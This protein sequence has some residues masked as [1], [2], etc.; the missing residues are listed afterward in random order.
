MTD[1]RGI[2]ENMAPV[3]ER[4]YVQIPNAADVRSYLSGANWLREQWD[5]IEAEGVRLLQA[6]TPELTYALFDLYAKT[7][8]R[9]EYERAYFERRRR[10]NT[11]ALLSLRSP[12][13]YVAPLLDILWAICDEYTW[14]IPAHLPDRL[15]DNEIDL[16]AAETGFALSE[17][18]VLLRQQLPQ[19]VQDRI[20]R[21][22]EGRVLTPFLEH[23]PYA[24]ETAIHNWS[25]VCAGSVGAA[26]LLLEEDARRLAD[27][28]ARTEQSM[29]HYLSGFGEDGACLE[30]IGYWKYGFGYFVYYADLLLTRSRGRMNW[31]SLEKVERIAEFQQKCFLCGD[32]VANFS[33]SHAQ[34]YVHMGLSHKLAERFPGV[35]PPP[36][37]LRA[38]YTEDHCSRLAPALRNLLWTRGGIGAGDWEGGSF[39]LPDAKWLVARHRSGSCAFGFAAKG[40]SND[41]P[42]N[43][44]DLGHFMLVAEETAFLC[45]LGA[46]EY[47]KGYFGD[48]RYTYDCNGSQGHS[49]PI[50]NGSCQAPGAE[51]VA[52]VLE[53][54]ANPDQD[55]LC[56]DISRAYPDQGLASLERHL[57]WDKGDLPCLKLVD[58]FRFTVPPESI[59]ERFVTQI[60]PQV[61][62]DGSVT[63]KGA[64]RRSLRISFD[65]G[66]YRVEVA[67]RS[68]A[69]HFG[70]Y[71]TWYSIDF[72]VLQP[73]RNQRLAFVFQFR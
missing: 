22:V 3:D 57:A 33:D 71:E 56:M 58:E 35:T 24:W 52:V 29:E 18:F 53:A 1:L 46:G 70:G 48:E 20:R 15:A 23:G 25:A 34:S 16:F 69:N 38:P 30:G 47:R 28:L 7:G 27:I 14:C 12:E 39:F 64:G 65:H 6:R 66:L 50:V 19:L 36:A 37:K 43:H 51:R 72:H 42:H 60:K 8:S 68:F 32:R 13:T 17:I 4:L 21:E 73:E 59:T 61:H 54:A 62:E 26:A 10:L 67:E 44:N 11:F 9:L 49:V 55:R 45:D 41:E 31:F 40:G 2:V 5:E 63:L